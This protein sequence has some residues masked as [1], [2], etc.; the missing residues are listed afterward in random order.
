[1]DYYL[2]KTLSI[3]FDDAIL[4]VIEE[5]EKEGFGVHTEI[6]MKDIFKKKLNV[7]FKKYKI[8]GACNPNFSYQALQIE[9]K[10]GLMLPCNAI[11][12]ENTEGKIE[13]SFINPSA[14]MKPVSNPDLE[15]VAR[16]VREKLKNVIKNL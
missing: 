1:M 16:V 7:E 13:V 12:T 5:L 2:T 15:Y 4:K 14:A 11:I 10:I 8:L 9:D 3:G 6:D